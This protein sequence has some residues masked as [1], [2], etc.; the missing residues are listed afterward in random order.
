[1]TNYFAELP[2]IYYDFNIAGVN[3]VRIL[4]DISTNIRFK[5]ELLSDVMLYDEYDIK[6]G[7]TPEI[8][9]EKVYGSPQYHWVIMLMNDRFD[10]VNDFPLSS[11]QLLRH[12]EEI[13][14]VGTKDAIHHYVDRRG[15]TLTSIEPYYDPYTQNHNIQCKL[16]AGSNIITSSMLH[17]FADHP[18]DGLQH[19]VFGTGIDP[20]VTTMIA[21]QIDDSTLTMS[22]VATQTIETTLS[23][24]H[25]IND[26]TY[27]TPKTN[28][29]HETE[30]NEAKRRIKLLHP[31]MIGSVLTQLKA[32]IHG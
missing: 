29:E 9:S 26:L 30:V 16:V 25:V 28:L 6:D 18:N 21:G 32:L 24:I 27:A 19:Q 12:V 23:F 2:T 22:S 8:I 14:G 4:R 1:M 3:E 17:A 10:Y 20:D 31:S 13:Y 15:Y 5:K 11:D 7:D